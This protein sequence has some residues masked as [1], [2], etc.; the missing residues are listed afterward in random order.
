[1]I[2]CNYHDNDNIRCNN[3]INPGEILCSL[4]LKQCN[5][6]TNQYHSCDSISSC[7]IE[8]PSNDDIIKYKHLIKCYKGRNKVNNSCYCGYDSNNKHYNAEIYTHSKALDCYISANYNKCSIKNLINRLSSNNTNKIKHDIYFCKCIYNNSLN[9]HN[10]ILSLNTSPSNHLIDSIKRKN[11]ILK[12]LSDLNSIEKEYNISLNDIEQEKIN[13]LNT[14]LSIIDI[15]FND[16]SNILNSHISSINKKIDNYTNN[17]IINISLLDS[18]DNVFSII[19]THIDH[20][21]DYSKEYINSLISN[22]NID[23][24]SEDDNLNYNSDIYIINEIEKII[25]SRLYN[26]ISIA[27]KFLYDYSILY[28]K[29]ETKSNKLSNIID[30]EKKQYDIFN[31][32][33]QSLLDKIILYMKES[34]SDINIE[35]IN[36]YNNITSDH[37]NKIKQLESKLI[38]VNK[39]LYDL[40]ISFKHINKINPNLILLF[41]SYNISHLYYTDIQTIYKKLGMKKYSDFIKD[42]SCIKLNK[43]NNIHKLQ[44]INNIFH[45]IMLDI[46]K[47]LDELSNKQIEIVNNLNIPSLNK[48]YNNIDYINHLINKFISIILTYNDFIPYNIQQLYISDNQIKT[49]LNYSKYYSK[50]LTIIDNYIKI[51]LKNMK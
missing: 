6:E 29:L 19:N 14:H 13:E 15:K 12:Y 26:I 44:T 1:M 41:K 9:T 40:T 11:I 37:I 34:I 8:S 10:Q 2:Q 42:L 43:D 47:S 36:Q 49:I 24:I 25:R 32:K 23:N 16:F 17:E 33:I 38:Y 7:N 27:S 31:N 45:M 5:T 20:I 46:K 35:Y 39:Q 51:F 50:D 21:H 22:K 30:N 4:H 48:K 18:I 28:D 3:Q